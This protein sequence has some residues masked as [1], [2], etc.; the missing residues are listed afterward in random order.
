MRNQPTRS[1]CPECWWT[2]FVIGMAAG[3]A[4]ATVVVLLS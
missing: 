4:L 3:S 2:G 1:H